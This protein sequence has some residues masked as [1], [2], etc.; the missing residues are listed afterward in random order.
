HGNI[1]CNP[2]VGHSQ[3]PVPTKADTS[4]RERRLP[5]G[6]AILDGDADQRET[7]VSS[8]RNV[9]HPIGGIK[10]TGIDDGWGC[11]T[12]L[13]GQIATADASNIQ[14]ACDSGCTSQA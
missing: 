6:V 12:G 11:P 9:D 5:G 8:C 1:A 13:N 14:I 7:G 10:T 3:R 4:T 2:A